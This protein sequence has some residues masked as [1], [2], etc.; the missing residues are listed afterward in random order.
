VALGLE[1]QGGTR[2]DVVNLGCDRIETAGGRTAQLTTTTVREWAVGG[3]TAY[4]GAPRGG[5]RA[6]AEYFRA[7]SR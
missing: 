1:E 2:W 3:V 4:V 5:D 6:L 7:P